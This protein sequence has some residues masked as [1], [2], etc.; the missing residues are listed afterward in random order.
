M[1]ARQS[2]VYAR[3]SH[4]ESIVASECQELHHGNASPEEVEKTTEN[5]KRQQGNSEMRRYSLCCK[6]LLHNLRV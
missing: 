2:H 6:I 5:K 1:L 4:A 3:P